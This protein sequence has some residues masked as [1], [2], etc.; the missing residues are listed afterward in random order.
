MGTMRHGT[1][2]AAKAPTS[3]TGP[4]PDHGCIVFRSLEGIPH[5]ERQPPVALRGIAE[6]SQ[7]TLCRRVP[8]EGA[9]RDDRLHQRQMQ[10]CSSSLSGDDHRLL[11]PEAG[12][13]VLL[14]NGDAGPPVLREQAPERVIGLELLDRG[15]AHIADR[16]GALE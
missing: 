4:R 14:W 12:T 6:C 2:P 1:G 15:R 11:E 5:G 9:R 8:R 10:E 16:A 7:K 3:L 13:A